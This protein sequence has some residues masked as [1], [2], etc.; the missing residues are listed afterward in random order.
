EPRP[1]GCRRV[2]IGI[3]CRI[4]PGSDVM[5]LA[6]IQLALGCTFALGI[7]LSTVHPWGNPCAGID[8]N[9][10]LMGTSQVP[11]NVR[12]ILET[13]CGDCHSEKTRYPI[14]AHFAPVSW[15]IDRDVHQGRSD[16]NMSQWQSMN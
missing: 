6:R 9:A 1:C 2:P 15:M 12:M 7:A 16:L 4:P 5:N 10:P 8:P 13:K 14:Y 3:D 11:G